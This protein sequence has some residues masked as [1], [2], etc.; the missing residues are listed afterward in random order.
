MR[1]DLRT[2]RVSHIATLPGDAPE[3]MVSAAGLLWIT[4]R[5][6]DL[7]PVRSA[8]VDPTGFPSTIEIG[9]SG[10]DPS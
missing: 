10:I 9:E 3:R 5:S 6:T 8:A 1:I 4:G 2:N 7:M